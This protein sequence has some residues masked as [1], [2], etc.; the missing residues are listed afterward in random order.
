M[1]LALVTDCRADKTFITR[2]L[3]YRTGGQNKDSEDSALSNMQIV[4]N[5]K[6]SCRG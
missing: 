5:D 1:S 2:E 3:I 6:I 4:Q